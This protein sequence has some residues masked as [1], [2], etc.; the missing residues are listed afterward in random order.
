[1]KTT[2]IIFVSILNA[3][4]SREK[5]QIMSSTEIVPAPITNAASEDTLKSVPH[6]VDTIA[7]N[8]LHNIAKIEE[9]V[10]VNV[11]EVATAE[12]ENVEKTGP[13][14]SS[15][16]TTAT[17]DEASSAVNND[18]DKVSE[19]VPDST[20]IADD[21]G[22]DEKAGPSKEDPATIPAEVKES[23]KESKMA[24]SENPTEANTKKRLAA[25]EDDCTYTDEASPSKKEKVDSQVAESKE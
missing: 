6:K 8:S 10:E 22:N 17:T 4:Y 15:A 13:T 20:E 18:S 5:L 12:G 14:S 2:S 19:N 3:L 1:M 16:A 24:E 11:T 7:G 25:N 23:K 9:K 21:N